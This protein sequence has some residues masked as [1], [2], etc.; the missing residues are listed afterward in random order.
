MDIELE[1]MTIEDLRALRD[2]VAETLKAKRAEA[3]ET[4]TVEKSTRDAEMRA[5]LAAGDKVIAKFG[6]GTVEAIV[7]RRSEKSVTISFVKD[8]AEVKKY[9]K[10]SEILKIVEKAAKAA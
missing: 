1:T 6:K 3:K 7:L 4:D 5:A 8:G 2:E 10:Y 9:R